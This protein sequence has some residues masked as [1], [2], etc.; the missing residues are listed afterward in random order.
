V[1]SAK[2]LLTFLYRLSFD[3]TAHVH[4]FGFALLCLLIGKLADPSFKA[5]GKTRNRG[6]PFS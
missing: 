3:I 5:F 6:Q 2:N 1:L 4:R